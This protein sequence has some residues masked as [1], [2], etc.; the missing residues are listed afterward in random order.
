M[1]RE[2]ALL[3]RRINF[4]ESSSEE[5]DEVQIRPRAMKPPQ[6]KVGR[7]PFREDKDGGGLVSPFAFASL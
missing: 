3:S 1:R 6:L 2:E 4:G 5:K 7:P